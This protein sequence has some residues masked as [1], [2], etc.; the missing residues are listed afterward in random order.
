MEQSVLGEQIWF[1]YRKLAEGGRDW[2]YSIC[3]GTNQTSLPS[4]PAPSRSTQNI[5]ESPIF[6][7][8]GVTQPTNKN[9]ALCVTSYA[10]KT[11]HVTSNVTKTP[12][13]PEKFSISSLRDDAI[14]TQKNE[15]L[16]ELPRELVLGSRRG[17]NR[18][19]EFCGLP[20]EELCKWTLR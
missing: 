1:T 3:A 4:S 10:C 18:G 8:E 20:R 19:Y 12:P 7:R 15:G 14:S 6:P 11:E 17:S 2:G 16:S 5:P 13:H 9:L